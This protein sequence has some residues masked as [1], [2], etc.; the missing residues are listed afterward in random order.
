MGKRQRHNQTPQTKVKRPAPF[1][2]PPPPQQA[3]TRHQQTDAHE[4]TTNSDKNNTNDPQKKHRPGIF[5]MRKITFQT[6]SNQN[7][8]I[9]YKDHN[10]IFDHKYCI[11]PGNLISI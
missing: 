9:F 11:D 2:P 5:Q 4:N 6:D 3:T 10:D 7:G 8:F 1:P